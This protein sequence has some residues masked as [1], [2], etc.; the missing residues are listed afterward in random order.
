M[1]LVDVIYIGSRR[2]VAMFPRHLYHAIGGN[3]RMKDEG[4]K[5][6]TEG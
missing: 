1:G 2:R 6:K 5:L 3:L 4:E